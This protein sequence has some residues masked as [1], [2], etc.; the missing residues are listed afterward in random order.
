MSRGW[1]SST[2]QNVTRMSESSE[3]FIASINRPEALRRRISAHRP[4]KF[5]PMN[6]PGPIGENTQIFNLDC[7]ASLIQQGADV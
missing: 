4:S 1:L 3:I 7:Y 6:Y 5:M 2:A